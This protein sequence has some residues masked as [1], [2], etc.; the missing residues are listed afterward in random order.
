MIDSG[1]LLAHSF[2]KFDRKGGCASQNGMK[3]MFASTVRVAV[4]KGYSHG[5]NDLMNIKRFRNL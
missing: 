3:L 1:I 4:R 5:K 2:F